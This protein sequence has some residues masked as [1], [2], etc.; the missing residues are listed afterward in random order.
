MV[1]YVTTSWSGHHV[2]YIFSMNA[3]YLTPEEIKK[4]KWNNS[5][6]FVVHIILYFVHFAFHLE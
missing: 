3:L 2:M 6:L 4:K 5:L 1:I